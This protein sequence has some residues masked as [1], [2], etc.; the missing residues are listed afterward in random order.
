MNPAA[1]SMDQIVAL[2]AVALM[3]MLAWRNL[4]S[5]RL[6]AGRKLGMALLWLVA[7]GL[8]ALLAAQ[9]GM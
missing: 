1:I 6:G 5:Y 2:I 9:F 4:S 8:I 3:L 7:F